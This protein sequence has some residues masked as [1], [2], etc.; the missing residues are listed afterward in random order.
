MAKRLS[1]EDR[2]CLFESDYSDFGAIAQRESNCLADNRPWVQI[3]LAPWV[4][5]LGCPIGDE[6]TC[7]STLKGTEEHGPFKPEVEGSI[8]SEPLAGKATTQ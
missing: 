2:E 6:Q 5:S 4:H 7:S 1:L 8:P 3:P